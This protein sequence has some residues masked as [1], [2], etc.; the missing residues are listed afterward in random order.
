MYSVSVIFGAYN[1]S[2][3]DYKDDAATKLWEERGE[4]GFGA[5][6]KK[7]SV[8]KR[9]ETVAVILLGTCTFGRFNSSGDSKIIIMF[10]IYTTHVVN[11]IYI[12][13]L[14]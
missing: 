3:D 1:T 8:T 12:Y 2:W 11:V 14:A 4:F 10:I 7:K 13:K 6:K 9:R 5:H